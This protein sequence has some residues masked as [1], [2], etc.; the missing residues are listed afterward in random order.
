MKGES[1]FMKAIFPLSPTKRYVLLS[2]FFLYI[3][4]SVFEEFTDE[5][6]EQELHFFDQTI[7]SL[8]HILRPYF[9]PI[10]LFFTF[11]GSTDALLL[12]TVLSCA[13]LIWKNKRWETCFLVVG[14]AFGGIFNLLLKWIFRRERPDLHRLIEETGYSYPSGHSMG[15]F[16]FYGMLC[17]L[18]I[19]FFPSIKSK[20]IFILSTSIFIFMIGLSRIYLGVHYPS[21]VIAGFAAGGA[22]VCVCLLVL[23]LILKTRERKHI[24]A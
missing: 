9:T 19:T 17:M 1:F 2:I 16:I 4:V 13:F 10:M 14:I 3:F 7:I 18:L 12:F 23:R 15:A 6:L 5:L 20:V 21:D 11:F 24:S 22:W 8:V